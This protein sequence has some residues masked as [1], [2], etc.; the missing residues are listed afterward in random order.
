DDALGVIVYLLPS[1]RS[2][3][4]AVGSGKSGGGESSVDHQ[5]GAEGDPVHNA[6]DNQLKSFW[7]D[8]EPTQQG[9]HV[10]YMHSI[11]IPQLWH[12]PGVKN[13]PSDPKNWPE[14]FKDSSSPDD[15]LSNMCPL[16]GEK[17]KE[18]TSD[19]EEA[20]EVCHERGGS[21]LR[22]RSLAG[23]PRAIVD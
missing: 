12:Q 19:E 22:W 2:L 13:E 15:S 20:T 10:V 14:S 4:A 5:G 6:Y 9:G 11:W 7:I 16:A 18:Q 1:R 8:R 3:G 23:R 21:G 17:S